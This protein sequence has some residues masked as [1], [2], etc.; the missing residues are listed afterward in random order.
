MQ[1]SLLKIEGSSQRKI[2][3]S[4]WIAIFFYFFS[5]FDLLK[6]AKLNFG[7]NF[8][9]VIYEIYETKKTHMTKSLGYTFSY[10]FSFEFNLEFFN[11]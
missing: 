1:L 10:K 3:I 4:S 7:T 5:I 11:T 2:A 6:S 8:Y 9:S